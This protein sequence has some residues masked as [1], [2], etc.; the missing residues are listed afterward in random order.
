M[1]NRTNET[2]VRYLLYAVGTILFFDVMTIITNLYI[3]PVL[4]GFG[5]PDIFIYIKT[6][7]FLVLFIVL[8]LWI[9][10][11]NYSLSKS[12]LK[13]LLWL[14]FYVL[15][16][17]FFSV[18]MYKYYL[19]VDTANII[20]NQILS[21]NPAL[22]FDLSRINLQS[23]TY[24]T[25]I[26]SGFNS[27]IILFAQALVFQ[28][29]IFNVK[30][31]EIEDEKDI[32][33][34]LFMFD[35]KLFFISLAHMVFV[36]L[37]INLLTFRYSLTYALEIGIAMVAFAISLMNFLTNSEVYKMRNNY[38]KQSSFISSHRFMIM[39]MIINTVLL[40]LLFGYNVFLFIINEGNYRV[41]ATLIA[42]GTAVYLLV[43]TKTILALE[44]K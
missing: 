31:F 8:S 26:F 6:L 22:V 20:K 38:C 39:L 40:S 30:S 41:G 11:S 24:I 18:Y 23:L 36:F 32:M 25:T 27:E 2:R 21:G 4:E 44:N 13:L 29:M 42:L 3:S 15:C 7:T 35:G 14:G 43:K 34:D 12:T 33:Y 9:K 28:A 1:I 19:I 16:F 17:Y 37:S 5:L 10:D